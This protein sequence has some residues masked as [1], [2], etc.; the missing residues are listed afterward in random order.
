MPT[1]LVIS[2]YFPPLSPAG[3]SI[4]L[5]KIIKFASE[6]ELVIYCPYS[7]FERTVIPE[8]RLSEFLL[9]EIPAETVVHRVANPFFGST[10]LAKLGRKFFGTSSL[11][12]GLSV[13]W[14]GWRKY[15]HT[16]PD[17]IFVNTPP[18]SN[19][20]AGWLLASLLGVPLFVDFKDDWVGSSEFQK[21]GRIR[22]SIES[23]VEKRIVRQILRCIYRHATQ[24]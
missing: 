23:W 22:Q 2:R 16:P 5:V 15:R 14:Q 17:C 24:H 19:V 20:F 9:T 18:F 21:K 8:E 3:A 6:L 13:C 4:R 10:T 12:W 11:P 7:G 1:A